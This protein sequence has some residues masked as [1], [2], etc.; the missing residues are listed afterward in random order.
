MTVPENRRSM[1]EAI[2]RIRALEQAGALTGK[3]RLAELMAMPE[4]TLRS[5]MQ[6]ERRMPATVLA[7]AAAGLDAYCAEISAHAAKLRELAGGD[8]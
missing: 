5:Y 8:K 2:V 1:A 6:V 4:R 3:A 7:A